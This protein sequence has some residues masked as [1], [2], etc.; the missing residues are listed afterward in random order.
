M[1]GQPPYGGGVEQVSVVLQHAGEPGRPRDERE[2]QLEPG[3]RLTGRDRLQGEAGKAE[4]AGPGA[5][6]GLGGRSALQREQ[7]LEQRRVGEAA[8]GAELVD[9]PLERQ[10]LVRV[11]AE[12]GLAGACQQ[13]SEGRVAPEVAAQGESIDEEADQALRLEAVA[14]GHRRA[15]HQVLLAGEARQQRL[16]AGEENHEEGRSA[17]PAEAGQGARQ[18]R[19]QVDRQAAAAPRRQRRARAVEGQIENGG[20]AGQMP[21]PP[22]ELGGE[23]VAGQPRALP[24]GEVGVLHR[25]RR[26]RRRPRRRGGGIERADLADEDVEGPGV[27][28]TVVE[29]EEHGVMTIRRAGG[30]AHQGGAHERSAGEVEGA[31]GVG[32]GEAGRL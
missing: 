3:H 24:D 23:G 17:L 2:G 15:D 8:L 5:P 11:G 7:D 12:G 1:A 18:L 6:G 21:A 31:G 29:V 26:Q 9:H 16:E 22:S 19:R 30:E 14:V 28:D 13:C 4:G 32:G 27:R 10:V 20:R 25:Q